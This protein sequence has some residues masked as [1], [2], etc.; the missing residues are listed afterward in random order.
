MIIDVTIKN[1]EDEVL[2]YEGLVLV[3]FW[4]TWCGPCRRFADVLHALD[5]DQDVNV[6]ICKVNID[7]EEDLTNGFKIMSIPTVLVYKNGKL[8]EN[9]LGGR[10]LNEMKNLVSKHL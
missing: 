9:F 6:K 4:A 2:N 10:S 3:D 8:V 7:E 1:F 5:D